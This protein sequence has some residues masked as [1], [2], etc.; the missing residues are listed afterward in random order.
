MRRAPIPFPVSL[1]MFV[2]AAI[3]GGAS[4]GGDG[5]TGP[6]PSVIPSFSSQPP[7]LTVALGEPA[8]FAVVAAGTPAPVLEWRRNGATIAGATSSSY[9]VAPTSMTDS[10]VVF[11]VVASNSAGATTSAGAVLTVTRSVSAVEVL[12]TSLSLYVG[13]VSELAVTLRDITGGS[14]TGRPVAWESSDPSVASVNGVG[15]VEARKVGTTSI[16]ATSEGKAG[17]A[18][19]QVAPAPV[20][21]VVVSPPTVNLVEGQ[22]AQLTATTQDAAGRTVTGRAVEWTSSDVATA[23]V[24]TTGFVTGLQAGTVTITATSEGRSGTSTVAVFALFVP[25]A[26]VR[27]SPSSPILLAPGQTVQL[28]AEVLDCAG[29]PINGRSVVWASSDD[30]VAAVS[31]TGLATAVKVGTATISATTTG[32]ASGSAE[33]RVTVPAGSAP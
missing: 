32:G 3:G 4:C 10:G 24:S 28:S 16:T 22:S 6:A 14:M 20:A 15:V 1:L 7:S 5:A 18:T 30:A 13:D 25:V 27:V 2:A 21:T 31:T 26:A 9:T 29:R 8:T 23:T 33:I 17:S 11:T 12:P 19:V